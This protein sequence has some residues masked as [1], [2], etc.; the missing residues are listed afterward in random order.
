MLLFFTWAPSVQIICIGK[1]LEAIQKPPTKKEKKRK[2]PGS[3]GPLA[4]SILYEEPHP[5]LLFYFFKGNVN[6]QSARDDLLWDLS[7]K[8]FV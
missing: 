7:N 6:G 1:Y 4:H 8:K 2:T 5:H 3:G